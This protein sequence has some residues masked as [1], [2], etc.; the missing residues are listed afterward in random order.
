MSEVSPANDLSDGLADRERVEH[1][2][3]TQTRTS[4]VWTCVSSLLRLSSYYI[5]DNL[6][7][8]KSF[9][10]SAPSIDAALNDPPVR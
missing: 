10:G 2:R 9:S 1:R 6:R 7:Y 5:I 8:C 4:V 3:E